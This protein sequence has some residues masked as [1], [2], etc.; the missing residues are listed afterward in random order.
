MASVSAGHSTILA[1]LPFH[2]APNAAIPATVI[3]STTCT[4]GNAGAIAGC[5]ISNGGIA[6]GTEAVGLMRLF[7]GISFSHYR[8]AEYKADGR[9]LKEGGSHADR[10]RTGPHLVSRTANQSLA[11]SGQLIYGRGVRPR[12]GRRWGQCLPAASSWVG[13]K[14][15]Q[16]LGRGGGKISKPFRNPRQLPARQAGEPVVDRRVEDPVGDARAALCLHS[17]APGELDDRRY[18]GLAMAGCR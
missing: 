1:S 9:A 16:D 3:R 12:Y 18:D 15:G 6:G 2:C 13:P 11:S 17:A 5:G 4:G 10:R 7:S 8:I 14:L